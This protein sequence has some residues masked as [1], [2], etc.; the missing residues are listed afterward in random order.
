MTKLKMLRATTAVVA[1]L[2]FGAGVGVVGATSTGSV[3]T[4]GPE[5]KVRVDNSTYARIHND[6]DVKV[7]NKN[8]QRASSGDAKVKL[9]TTGGDA[10]SGDASNANSLSADLSVDNSGS[11][12]CVNG[13][14][15]GSGLDVNT[16]GPR[17]H[18]KVDNSTNLKVYNDNYVKVQN[19][20]YQSAYTG[21]ATV[22]L[23]TTGGSATTGSA[24]N[25][26]STDVTVSISN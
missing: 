11:C 4:S 24:S 25:T 16:S 17:A 2:T 15:E 7:E 13:S 20:N 1:G 14:G 22:S 21:D 19:T 9:N 3:D 8:S 10:K 26:N 6:N 5:A 23:N 12:G 18:V